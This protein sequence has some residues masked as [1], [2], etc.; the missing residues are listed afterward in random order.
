ME[1]PVSDSCIKVSRHLDLR[2]SMLFDILKFH[3]L[4]L[5]IAKVEIKTVVDHVHECIYSVILYFFY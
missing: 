1:K 2:D 5:T 3:I 4:T